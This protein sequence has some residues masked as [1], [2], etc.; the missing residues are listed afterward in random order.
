MAGPAWLCLDGYLQCISYSQS[1]P[2]TTLQQSTLL[3]NAFFLALLTSFVRSLSF[4]LSRTH[5]HPHIYIHTRA[6]TPKQEALISCVFSQYSTSL[7]ATIPSK[8]V[9]RL[10]LLPLSVYREHDSYDPTSIARHN[11][12]P[13]ECSQTTYRY[14]LNNKGEEEEDA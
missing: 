8:I 9:N 12:S 14:Q 6:R 2:S 10:H 1:P 5:R 11:Q 4:T 7:L 3:L 13:L